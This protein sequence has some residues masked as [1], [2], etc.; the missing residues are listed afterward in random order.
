MN[1]MQHWKHIRPTLE[2][3]GEGAPAGS[4]PASDPPAADPNGSGNPPA[5]DP[6]WSW[7]PE[8]FR[9]ENGP[10]H[11]GFRAYAEDMMAQQ[12][13]AQE[14]LA[15]VPEDATGY[16]FAVPEDIDFGEMELP[17]DFK[18]EL[19]ADDPAMAPLFEELGGIMH[20]FNMPKAAAGKL[21]G[22]LAKYEASK[23]S[24]QFVAGNAEYQSLG[25][26]ADARISNVQRALS[27][28]LSDDQ[29]TALMA[30][31]NSANGV[32]ALEALLRPRG[33]STTPTEPSPQEKDPLAARYPSSAK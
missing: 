3:S 25:P 30:A 16:E 13:I 7:Y 14:A 19:K 12:A 6:D 24:Q 31:T 23:F 22:V 5:G 20:E 15:E 2:A 27:N 21:L 26:T 17:D 8:Q 18:V 33:P 4:P 29:A 11:E 1:L 28:R 9:G 10:D 32:K